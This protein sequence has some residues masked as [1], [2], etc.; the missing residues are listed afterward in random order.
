M[1]TVSIE[2][3]LTSEWKDQDRRDFYVQRPVGDIKKWVGVGEGIAER[4]VTEGK[5][6]SSTLFDHRYYVDIFKLL[7]AL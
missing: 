7:S 4:K 1:L 2:I 5:E 3:T 6:I